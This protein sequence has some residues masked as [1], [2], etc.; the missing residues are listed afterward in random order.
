MVNRI[1]KI[2]LEGI[3]LRGTEKGGTGLEKQG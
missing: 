2:E 3:G 1:C